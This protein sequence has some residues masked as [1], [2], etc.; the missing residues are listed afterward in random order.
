[1]TYIFLLVFKLSS[2]SSKI[3]K[4]IVPIENKMYLKVCAEAIREDVN[5]DLENNDSIWVNVSWNFVIFYIYYIVACARYFL[6]IKTF[7]GISSMT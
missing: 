4:K 7:S 1:M 6:L 3:K 2:L 5:Y